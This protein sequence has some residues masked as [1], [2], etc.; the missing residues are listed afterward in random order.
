MSSGRIIDTLLR[1]ILFE[2]Q[3]SRRL[4]YSS[5]YNVGEGLAEAPQL[6][7]LP[8]TNSCTREGTAFGRAICML[9]RTLHQTG[10]VDSAAQGG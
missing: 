6:R 2:Q 7:S 9:L 1:S 4:L 10:H 8:K 3:L 5:P